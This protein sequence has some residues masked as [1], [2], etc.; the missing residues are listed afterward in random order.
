MPRAAL[1]IA[2][3]GPALRDGLMPV[4][5]LAPALLA[6]GHAV[7]EINRIANGENASVTVNAKADFVRGCFAVDLELVQ[8]WTKAIRDMLAG[9]EA[10]AIAN[11][12]ALLGGVWGTVKLFG[13]RKPSRA[14][15]IQEGRV[16]VEFPDGTA[17]EIDRT[18]YDVVRDEAVRQYLASTLK[19]LEQDGI[20]TF[21]LF[22]GHSGGKPLAHVEKSD[23]GSFAVTQKEDT[24]PVERHGEALFRIVTLSFQDDGKWRMHDGRSTVWVTIED[25]DFLQ[26]VNT[27]AVAFAKDDIL[28]CR[29]IEKQWAEG[30]QIKTETVVPRVLEHIRAAQQST[31]LLGPPP[32]LPGDT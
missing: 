24:P 19:P 30:G 12:L 26:R 2:F 15:A 16:R 5:D 11:L 31:L 27:N 29:V 22:S 9:P 1:R 32:D 13:G 21:D 3:D 17:L 23:L 8:T 28:R 20:D 18:M 14:V 6:F 10:T 7:E 25:Q 4:R